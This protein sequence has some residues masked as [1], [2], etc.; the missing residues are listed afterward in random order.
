MLGD[1]SEVPSDGNIDLETIRQFWDA[2]L[3]RLKN[4]VEAKGPHP[5][6]PSIKADVNLNSIEKPSG[7]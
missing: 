1:K 6:Q 4:R 7:C 3:I 2:A 5:L